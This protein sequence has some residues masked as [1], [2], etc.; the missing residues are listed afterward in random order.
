MSH[1][2]LKLCA[3]ALAATLLLFTASP[4]SAHGGVEHGKGG[5][6]PAASQPLAGQPVAV[7]PPDAAALNVI[8][9]RYLR[10]VK[11]IFKRT[12]FDCHSEQT[13]YP[14][15][16]VIPGVRQF[17]DWDIREARKHMDMNADFPFKGHGTPLK[18]LKA[19][20]KEVE[21]GDM[22][23]FYYTVPHWNERLT[24]DEVQII[25]RW[26]TEGIKL[27]PPGPPEPAAGK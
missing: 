6:P 1:F 27:L 2:I 24:R 3:G 9:N 26:A 10:D 25:L 4:A 19:I 5:E 21:E 18:D 15:Y 16:Y 17:I 8:N 22:P 14:A 13:R 7:P 12:C 11:P 23:P 20:Q